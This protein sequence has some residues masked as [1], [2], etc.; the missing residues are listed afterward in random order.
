MS[1]L[2]CPLCKNNFPAPFGWPRPVECPT[3]K[4][5]VPVPDRSSCSGARV[6]V[7]GLLA[8]ALG[9]GVALLYFVAQPSPPAADAPP[10]I[11]EKPA[12]PPPAVEPP[13]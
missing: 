2:T 4:S 9:L 11:F 3:C 10:V 12:P 5:P 13:V 6:G 7:T 1:V 8:L